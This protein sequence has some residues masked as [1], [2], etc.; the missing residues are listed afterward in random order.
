[1]RIAWFTPFQK[2]SAI[3][4]FSRLVTTELARSAEVDIW[5]PAAEE[6][7]PTQLPTISLP[8]DLVLEPGALAAYDMCVYN[9]GDHLGFHRQVFQTARTI[10]GVVVLHDFV[11]HHFFA[12]YYFHDQN[13]PQ[14]YLRIMEEAL[15]SGSQT[16]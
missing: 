6:T 9:L 5:H 3:G 1:V 2:S 14:E 7:H 4:R 8:D 10:P 11:M 13:N 15:V 12:G 16:G